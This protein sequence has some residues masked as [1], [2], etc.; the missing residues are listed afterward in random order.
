MRRSECIGFQFKPLLVLASLISI[1]MP[2]LVL[3]SL[4]VWAYKNTLSFNKNGLK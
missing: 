1:I 4:T 2:L 3:V